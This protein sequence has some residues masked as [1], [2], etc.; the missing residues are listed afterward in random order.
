MGS[1]AYVQNGSFSTV[2][3]R[4]ESG[5]QAN[6][7]MARMMHPRINL[8]QLMSEYKLLAKQISQVDPTFDPAAASVKNESDACRLLLRKLNEMFVKFNEA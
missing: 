4:W 5:N 2:L 8:T 3:A 1:L 6:V 7:K